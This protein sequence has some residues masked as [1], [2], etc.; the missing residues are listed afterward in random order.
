MSDQAPSVL[1][2]ARPDRVVVVGAGIVGAATALYLAREGVNVTLVDRGHAQ[3]GASAR[4]AGYISMITRTPGPAL[5]R[6]VH[7]RDPQLVRPVRLHYR[8][9]SRPHAAAPTMRDPAG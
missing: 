6:L 8:R 1:G 3:F 9:V 2:V 4:S 5:D 7:R